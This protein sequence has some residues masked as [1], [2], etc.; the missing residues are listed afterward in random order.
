MAQLNYY[1]YLS[2]ASWLIII[3]IIYYIYTK[4]NIIP[5]ILEKIRIKNY[6]I[7]IKKSRNISLDEKNTYTPYP[8]SNIVRNSK[9]TKYFIFLNK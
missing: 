9:L 1:T 4:Q 8:I 6:Y 2:Q 3:Y 5:G 7:E